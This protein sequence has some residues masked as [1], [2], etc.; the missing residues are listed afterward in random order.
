MN[1]TIPGNFLI[2]SYIYS[3]VS[4]PFEPGFIFFHNGF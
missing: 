4:K 1:I 2:F 3:Q